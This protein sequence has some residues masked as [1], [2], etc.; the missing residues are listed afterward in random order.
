MEDEKGQGM[1]ESRLKRIED[2][3][4]KLSDGLTELIRLDERMVTLFK[5]MDHYDRRAETLA[6][7]VAALETLNH[8]R[9]PLFMWGERIGIA[10]IGAGVATWV[11]MVWGV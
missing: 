6:D 10:L 11:K 2:K 9:G 3:L 4:D 5:R 8:R 7:R 1:E